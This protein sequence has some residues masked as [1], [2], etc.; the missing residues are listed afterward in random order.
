MEGC[1]GVAM[2]LLKIQS[3]FKQL[4]AVLRSYAV[5]RVLWVV[6]S[7]QKTLETT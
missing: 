6:A 4:K 7:I 3:G 1:Q 5:A 2:Q